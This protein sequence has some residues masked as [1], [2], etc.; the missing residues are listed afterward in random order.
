MLHRPCI[1]TTTIRQSPLSP[2]I[3]SNP[4]GLRLIGHG[5]SSLSPSLA[6][7]PTCLLSTQA[8]LATTPPSLA[9]K[10]SRWSAFP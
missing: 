1:T 6:K 8:P 5:D 3:A 10:V 4:N 7:A 9:T 2:S